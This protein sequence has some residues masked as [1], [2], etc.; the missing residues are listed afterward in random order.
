MHAQN[1]VTGITCQLL[2]PQNDSFVPIHRTSTNLYHRLYLTTVITNDNYITDN[3]LKLVT[4]QGRSQDFHL[5]GIN[6]LVI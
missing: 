3:Q 4:N 6:F 2:T 1:S 5:G